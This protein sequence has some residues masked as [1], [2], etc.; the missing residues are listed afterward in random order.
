[1]SLYKHHSTEILGQALLDNLSAMGREVRPI[2]LRHGADQFD[3]KGWYPQQT[4]LDILKAISQEARIDLMALGQRVA[5]SLE[6]PMGAFSIQSSLDYIH[7]HYQRTHRNPDVVPHFEVEVL[8]TRLIKITDHTPYPDDLQYGFIYGLFER[9]MP[10]G[11]QLRVRYDEQA[12]R[13]SD[14]ADQSVYIVT[15]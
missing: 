13:R 3:P 14:G 4:W 1:M 12:C 8:D 7:Q 6:I 15:W 2:A 9:L 5:A 10:F 11:A